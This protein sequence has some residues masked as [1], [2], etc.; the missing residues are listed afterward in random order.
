MKTVKKYKIVYAQSYDELEK[1]VNDLIPVGWQPLGGI[2]SN[3]LQVSSRQVREI[4]QQV[5]VMYY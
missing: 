3:S 4:H 2:S 1:L 5:M